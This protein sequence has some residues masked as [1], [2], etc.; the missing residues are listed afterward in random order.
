M[1]DITQWA[2]RQNTRL[3]KPVPG[4]A[5]VAQMIERKQPPSVEIV[6]S[7]VSVTASA[8]A[9]ETEEPAPQAH[10][11]D[12]LEQEDVVAVTARPFS[13]MGMLSK[14]EGQ[15]ESLSIA[16]YLRTFD[17]WQDE[18]GVQVIIRPDSDFDPDD[19]V[20]ATFG[21]GIV[22]RVLREISHGRNITYAVEF[23]DGHREKVSLLVG[24]VIS[25]LL[26]SL[27]ASYPLLTGR[28]FV[29]YQWPLMNSSRALHRVFTSGAIGS[30]P[31]TSSPA[32]NKASDHPSHVTLVFSSMS[33]FVTSSYLLHFYIYIHLA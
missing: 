24:D 14:D 23:G 16:S 21:R 15:S 22:R 11:L 5:P 32:T 30:G 6:S 3:A 13:D 19:Y 12:R 26:L 17:D 10:E 1:V 33:S 2:P 31:S 25:L 20:D 7:G 4:P 9:S 18:Q 27:S 29:L 28:P 8:S